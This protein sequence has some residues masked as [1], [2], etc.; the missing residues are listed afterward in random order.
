MYQIS[1]T[2]RVKSLT[3]VDCRGQHRKERILHY[4]VC[5]GGY[6]RVSLC[7]NNKVVQR[8]I[9]HLVLESFVG[10][11]PEGMEACHNNGVN[12]DNNVNN[13]R[14]DTPLNNKRDRIKHGTYSNGSKNNLSKL[15]EEDV[16]KIRELS[17][18]RKK[19]G[20]MLKDIYTM[21]GIARPTLSGILSRR[22]W[23]HI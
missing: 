5:N 13:L 20:L 1:S 14:W 10:P 16:I 19:S 9:H 18:N 15:T 21:F 3:R 4:G 23:K 22:T 17:E 12:T 8:K 11:R 6:L 7:K 2:G